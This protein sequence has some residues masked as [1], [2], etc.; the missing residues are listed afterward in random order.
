MVLLADFSPPCGYSRFEDSIT[1]LIKGIEHRV[2]YEK[3]QN[4]WQPLPPVNRGV[5]YGVLQEFRRRMLDGPRFE[6]GRVSTQDFLRR[7]PARKRRLYQQAAD[8]LRHRRIKAS[9]FQ[10]KAFIKREKTANARDKDPRIIMP[11]AYTGLLYWGR[12]YFAIEGEVYRR[13]NAVFGGPPSV[14]KGMNAQRMAEVLVEK[15]SAFRRP[16]IVMLDASR[17]D[18]HTRGPVIDWEYDL[19]YEMFDTPTRKLYEYIL[20]WLKTSS[21]VASCR[22]GTVKFRSDQ[23]K[24]GFPNTGGGNT[25]DVLGALFETVRTVPYKAM[26]GAN[27]DDCFAVTEDR[28]SDHFVRHF[29]RLTTLLGWRYRCDAVAHE[30]EEIEFCQG[31]PVWT[32]NGYV[33]TRG[34]KGLAKDCIVKKP[35][36][37]ETEYRRWLRTI[38]QCGAAISSGVPVMQSLFQA[39]LRNSEGYLPFKNDELFRATALY[40]WSKG[41]K[42]KKVHVSARARASFAIATGCDIQ[43]QRRLEAEYDGLT[44]AWCGRRLLGRAISSITDLMGF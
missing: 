37:N 13:L 31:H 4:V 20:P 11:C 19:Y 32:E 16:V 22:D 42:A 9:D 12:F 2:L 10:V 27:G 39:M 14:M 29:T 21:V 23:R 17:H 8:V 7:Y 44:V 24:S 40:Q 3:V 38:G 30:I 1:V 5:V 36:R 41:M 33:M 26:V 28:N 18:Q 15:V 6:T 35:I 25:L 34:L 43:T